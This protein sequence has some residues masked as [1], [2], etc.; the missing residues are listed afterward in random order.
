MLTTSHVWGPC[1]IQHR[2][3]DG[4]RQADRLFGLIVERAGRFKFVTYANRL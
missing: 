3:S 1:A 4:S 2:E